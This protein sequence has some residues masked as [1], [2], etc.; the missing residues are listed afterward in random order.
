DEADLFVASDGPRL[1]PDRPTVFMGSRGVFDFELTLEL[2]EGG[3]HSGNWGGLLANP[4]IILAQALASL[5]NRKGEILVPEWRPPGPIPRKVSAAVRDLEVTGGPEGPEIDPEWGE[6]G[7]S[8]GEKVFGWNAFEI[9]AFECGNPK[10]PVGAIPPKASAFCQLRYVVPTDPKAFMPGLRRYLDAQGFRDI[11]ISP[12]P[13]PMAATR[14]D[15]DHP[16]VRFVVDSIERTTGKDVAVLPNL[17]GSLPNDVF[18]DILGLPTIWVPHSYAACSQH[19]PNEH[20]LEP[21]S[22]EALQIMA[23]LFWD[24]GEVEFKRDQNR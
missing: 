2:R 13:D 9:L 19:A 10:R 8:P 1:A 7:L 11:E 23:G 24:L 15:P 5:T 6:A 4:G 20:I 17:G 22:R 18:A 14:L 12:Q 3:H 21:V 16:W